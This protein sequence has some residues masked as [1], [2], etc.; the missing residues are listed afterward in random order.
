[1]LNAVLVVVLSP[2]MMSCDTVGS[3]GLAGVGVDDQGHLVG[4]LQM[5]EHQVDGATLY[6]T[7]GQRHLGEWQAT[8]PVIGFATW[9]MEAPSGGW[10]EMQTYAPPTGNDEYSLYGW[11]KDNT[12]GASSITFHLTDLADVRPNE[13]LY[14]S[15]RLG[16]L[17]RAS[18]AQFQHDAC[19]TA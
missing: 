19:P 16:Q 5:C 8:P 2:L 18:K 13:I 12:W 11:T 17:T 15:H 10:T 1:M 6:R 14:Q 9:S 7:N 3:A 4:Y